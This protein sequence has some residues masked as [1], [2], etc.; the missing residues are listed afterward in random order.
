VFI[1]HLAANGGSPSR[2]INQ[3]MHVACDCRACACAAEVQSAATCRSNKTNGR[4]RPNVPGYRGGAQMR[5]TWP[6]LHELN[7]DAMPY[8]GPR[9][10][11]GV[12]GGT[13]DVCPALPCPAA[14][15]LPPMTSQTSPR[16]P[17]RASSAGSPLRLITHSSHVHVD[18]SPRMSATTHIKSVH[19]RNLGST[20]T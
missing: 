3:S 6:R 16:L 10:V 1:P 8:L 20:A 5:A 17:P 14:V 19:L 18:Q 4:A 11:D 9:G 15:I 7:I 13:L 2:D 12:A